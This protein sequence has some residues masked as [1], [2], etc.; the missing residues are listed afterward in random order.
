MMDLWI[1]GGVVVLLWVPAGAFFI[2]F[3]TPAKESERLRQELGR[4]AVPYAIVFWPLTIFA[5]WFRYKREEKEKCLEKL[6]S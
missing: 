2:A 3:L 4:D 1:A 5:I 6:E